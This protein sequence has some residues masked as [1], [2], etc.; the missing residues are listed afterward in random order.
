[1]SQTF[2]PVQMAV[3]GCGRIS[4]AH[5]GAIKQQPQ[6]GNLVAI[7]DTDVD[8]ARSYADRHNVPMVFQNIEE[9]LK[10]EDIEAFDLCL[11]NHVHGS[12]SIQCLAAGRHV[13]VEKP[14]ADDAATAQRMGA[15]AE[16]TGTILAT[17]QSRRHSAAIRYLQD[18]LHEF[19][20]L[21]SIQA[22][23]C[24]YWPGPQAPW[25][26]TRPR[27]KGLVILMLGS[28]ALDF[29]QMMLGHEPESIYA[30]ADRWRDCWEAEDE[31]MFLLR[32][33]DKRLASV[34]L[35]YNQLP[36]FERYVLLFDDTVVEIR[37]VNTLIVNDQLV[38]GPPK[39]EDATLLITNEL[40]R[41][42]FM[43]FALAVRGL[44][45]RS[46]L[47][48][49]GVALMRVLQAAIESSLSG[50]PIKLTWHRN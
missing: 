48:P 38:V 28:H 46:A 7:V 6:Y 16:K 3:V 9:A 31:A 40:F 27:E 50:R 19:G 25:W 35:S 41:H 20:N 37:D 8:L 34:H 5:I 36:Y 45:N 23:F 2:K 42:Q 4:G 21:R 44:P 26:K 15:A 1:M 18:H 14:M 13:L 33:P 17:A 11:P 49:Q 47:H 32:Y 10:V 39:G 43:E 12:A 24:M 30:E 29:V 22:S